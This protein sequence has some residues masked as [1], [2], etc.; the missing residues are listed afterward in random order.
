MSEPAAFLAAVRANPVNAALLS[1]LPALGLPQ[2]HLA[3]GCLFQALWNRSAGRPAGWG[4]Q[5][6][7]VC[8][9]DGDDL[10][11]EAEDTVIR[12]VAAAVGDLGV[13]VE[14]RNQAR[15]HLWYPARFGAP[16]PPLASARDGIGRYL[17]AG[18]CIGIRLADGALHAPFGLADAAA[19]I[20]RPNPRLANPAL[21]RRKAQSY[22]ARWPFLTIVAEA[23]PGAACAAGANGLPVPP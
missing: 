3:A 10:S 22:R 9:F 12:R 4:V 14:V 19:G 17:V 20:L 18:T 6:Y 5:D 11:W 2:G 23:A 1:R 15:V 16:Y 7:D 21:F 8:Y 13:T